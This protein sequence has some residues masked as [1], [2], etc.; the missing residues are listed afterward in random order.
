VTTDLE[1]KAK[2]E[3]CEIGKLLFDKGF[4]AANDGNISVRISQNEILTTPTRV[5][6]GFLKPDMLVKVNMD[7][8]VIEGNLKPSS[9]LKMHLRVYK[10]R[11]EVGAVVH[12]HPP[13]ATAFAIAGIPLNQ[14]MMPE[15]VV[16]LGTVPIA[17]YGTPSTEEIPN[18]VAK[19]VKNHNALLLENH[20]ALTWGADLYS[21]YFMM[22]SLEFTA[23]INFYVKLLGRERELSEERVKQLVALREKMGYTGETPKGIPSDRD[24]CEVPYHEEKKGSLSDKD[25]N[26]IVQK[27]S[28]SVLT[29]L[30]KWIGK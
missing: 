14:A 28:E 20:G 21:A 16:L 11:P 30:S 5:S 1:Y 12:A 27:V 10:E 13:H 24:I 17:E 26:R 8:E 15:S 3:I 4:V 6:K 18:A 2:Q 22:E 23:R 29:H 9:E 25:I 19:Y 7:G